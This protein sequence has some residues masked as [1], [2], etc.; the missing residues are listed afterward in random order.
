MPY[1]RYHGR[2]TS[3]EEVTGTVQ[4]ATAD[5][6]S[7]MLGDQ[8]I[9]ILDITE[10]QH[11]AWQQSLK[12]FQRVPQRDLVIFSRQ[13]AVIVSATIPLVQGLRILMKQIERPYFQS[14]ISEIADDVEGGAKLSAA[15]KRYPHIFSTFYISVVMAGETSGKLDDVL[16]YLADQLERDYD[17]MTKIRGAMMYPAFV[18]LGMVVVGA[19]MMVMVVPQLT[20]IIQET[21]GVLPFSTR[22]LIGISTVLTQYWWLLIILIGGSIGFVRWWI[23]T[24]SGRYAWDFAT[25]RLPIFGQLIQKV[26]IVRLMRSLHTLLTGGVTLS[27]ALGVVAE[28]SG[29]V[30]YRDL[31]LE[32]VKEVESGNPLAAT[33]L[34]SEHVPPMVSQMLN[35]GERTGRLDEMLDKIAGFYRREVDTMIINLVSLLEPLIMLVM[36]VAVGLLVAAIIVPIY[37]L[38]STM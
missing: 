2:T 20:A 14:V 18:I 24:P 16:N 4:A 38:A 28:V 29:N 25:L 21:G 30:I 27:R 33:L 32:A 26:I 34:K 9:T 19:L 11:K 1:F 13:L 6:V 7:E 36:G 22:M 3:Q 15:F 5:I 8:Q 31:L 10:E 35:L 37:N 12:I 23:T 17:L